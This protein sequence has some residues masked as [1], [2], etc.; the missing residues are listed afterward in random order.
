MAMLLSQ[1]LFMVLILGASAFNVALIV[2][3]VICTVV[4]AHLKTCDNV[5]LP[6]VC[7][8][9]YHLLG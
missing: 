8:I 7:V 1:L 5:S 4:E 6:V 2:S 3:S 9:V